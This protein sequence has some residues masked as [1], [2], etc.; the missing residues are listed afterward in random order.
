MSKIIPSDRPCEILKDVGIGTIVDEI[1]EQFD[2]VVDDA[3]INN[4]DGSFDSIVQ[5]IKLKL[6]DVQSH[7]SHPPQVDELNI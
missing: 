1:A 3:E 6:I 2:I 5:L 4:L 7:K